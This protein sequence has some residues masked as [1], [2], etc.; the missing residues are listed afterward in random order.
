MI[1]VRQT[2]VFRGWFA[3]LKDLRARS[4]IARRIATVQSGL[5]GDVKFFDGIGELRI[6][7]GPG[8]R[9]YFVRKGAVVIILLCGGDKGSQARDIRKARMMAADLEE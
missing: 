8:Y 3:E 9:V 5:L 2:A 6:D 7:Y 1:E 4:R